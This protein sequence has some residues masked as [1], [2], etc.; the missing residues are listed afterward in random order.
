VNDELRRKIWP[1]LLNIDAIYE[2]DHGYPKMS[3]YK[4]STKYSN[5]LL[6]CH[7]RFSCDTEWKSKLNEIY[8]SYRVYQ[9][10]QRI[11]LNTEGY[12]SVP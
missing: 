4:P 10:T 5:P 7:E 8:G 3:I 2:K 1:I 12:R 9:K 11:R 6:T